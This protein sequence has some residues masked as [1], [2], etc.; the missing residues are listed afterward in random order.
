MDVKT[1]FLYGNL[2]EN[3][4]MAQPEGFEEKG[5]K[6]YVCLLQKSLYGLKQSLRQWYRRFD[7]FMISNVYHMSKYDSCIYREII[8]SSGAVYLLLYVD[9][10]L[11]AGKHLSDIEKLK[12]LLKGKFEM[13]YLGSAKRIL[14]ID[15]IRNRATGTLFLSQS[16][17][18]SKVL[19]RFQMMDSKPILTPL[20]AQFKLSNDMS[21]TSYADEVQMADIPYSQAVES[22]MYAMVCTRVDIAYAVSVMS[23]FMSN[24]GK[25]HWDA[26]KW[27]MRYLKGTLDHGLMYGKSKHEVCEVRGYVDSDFA[28]EFDRRKSISGYLFM[29]DNCLISWKATLQHILALSST[30]AEFIA[31]TEAAKESMWLKGLLNELWLKQRTV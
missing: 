14:G 8:N 23:R 5:Y 20:G 19:E 16:R 9:D 31:A 28:G 6:D 24:P 15:I 27:I 10:I 4:L 25:L 18:I 17:Y 29:L 13:K 30:E 7:Q 22:L 2:E 11:I 21:P 3:I 26:V 12:N 1:A